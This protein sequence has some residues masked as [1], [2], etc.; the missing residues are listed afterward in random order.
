MNRERILEWLAAVPIRGRI[1][2]Y[3]RERVARA[4]LVGGTVRDALLDRPSMDLDLTVETD[5]LALAQQTAN[6]FGGAFVPL[7]VDRDVGRVVLRVGDRHLHVDIAGLRAADITADLW[8]R[9]YTVNAMAVRLDDSLEL[10]DP[11]GGQSDL[12]ARLLRVA[13]PDAFT[14]D[15]LRVLRGVRLRGSLGFALTPDTE[16]LIRRH[17]PALASVSVERVRDELAQILAL[18]DAAESLAYAGDLGILSVILPEFSG[19][20]ILFAQGT[21]AVAALESLTTPLWADPL[22]PQVRSGDAAEVLVD[23]APGLVESWSQELT[24]GRTRWQMAKLAALLCVLP[25]RTVLVE[26]T[27][28]RLHLAKTEMRFLRG[29]LQGRETLLALGH[30]TDLEPLEIY[31]YYR[32]VGEAG[33]ASVALSLAL[34]STPGFDEADLDRPV[35]YNCAR[36]LLEAWFERHATLVEPPQLLSGHDMVLN[37]PINPGPILGE[38]VELLR[39][40]QVQGL[41]VTR[42][43]AL[44]Y[45]RTYLLGQR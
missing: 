25:G 30:H 6:Y 24:V 4:Y 31:R 44:S 16:V 5:A 22:G 39:E 42:H 14:N 2:D 15:P 38:L 17:A 7:D 45:L 21:R 19:N 20:D 35:L 26:P 28:R 29:M 33:L 36:L 34:T 8:A 40:V 41:V 13:R 12:Q 43:E 1:L 37:L 10:L 9:D 11:T 3:V 32:E 27:A 23:Y 18:E